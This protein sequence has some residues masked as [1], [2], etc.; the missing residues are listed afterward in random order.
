MYVRITTIKHEYGINLCIEV[1][2]TGKGMTEY[3][4]EKVYDSF[5]QAD[6]SRTRQGGG[7]GL[8]LAITS[9]FVALL[10]GFMTID[11]KPDEGTRVVL[12]IPASKETNK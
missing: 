6:S 9:G 5:Y 8:G 1:T 7:L 4:L 3:E 12:R 2:D 10:G 11:S